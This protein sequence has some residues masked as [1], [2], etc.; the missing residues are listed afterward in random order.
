MSR[1]S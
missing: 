1:I